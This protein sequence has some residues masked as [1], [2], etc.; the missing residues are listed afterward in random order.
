VLAPA[1]RTALGAVLEHSQQLGLLGPGPIDLHVEHSLALAEAWGRVPERFLDLGSGGGVPGLVLSLVWPHAGAVLLDA[2]RRST[3]NL[4]A[5]VV[6]LGLSPRVE[7][8]RGRAEALAR[9]PGL[10]S[11]FDLVMARG[12]G[13]PAITAECGVAFLRAG[14]EMVVT[15]PPGDPRPERWPVVGLR[16]LGLSEP[17]WIRL[18]DAGAVVLTAARSVADRWPRRSGVPRKRPLWD[19]ATGA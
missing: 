14:G 11:G 9:E 3:E 8:R 13:A 18:G 19:P 4:R 12:F 10:R 7:V 17:R 2:H 15:E 6:E 1:E 5:A 16:E